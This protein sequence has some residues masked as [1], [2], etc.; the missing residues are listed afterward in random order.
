MK[1]TNQLVHNAMLEL[2]GE[3]AIPIVNFL[4]NRK[5]ISEFIVSE[6][7]KTEIHL[8]RNIL[9]RMESL[10]LAKYKRRKNKEKGYYISYWTL[11]LKRI[12]DLLKKLEKDKLEKLKERLEKEETNKNNFFICSKMCARLDFE[13]ATNFGFRCP[14][15]GSLLQQQDN[16]KTIEHL[17]E[18]IGEIE[19]ELK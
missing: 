6:K 4:K 10:N 18:K 5:D 14:E 13:Q 17:R 11:N 8:V 16:S 12:K 1:L 19:K 7:T 9:Y 3:D 15:C 2:V